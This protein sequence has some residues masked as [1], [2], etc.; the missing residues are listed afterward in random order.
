[1]TPPNPPSP[2]QT[3]LPLD[4]EARLFTIGYEGR[5]LEQYLEA[6]REAGVTLLCDVRRDPVSRKPGFS[7]RRLEEAC[8]VAGI[9]YA[10]LRELGIAKE[11]RQHVRTASDHEA[12]FAWYAQEA[13]PARVEAITRIRGWV[14]DGERVALTCYE[15]DPV[16]CHRR[17]VADAVVAA[18]SGDSRGGGVA[19]QHL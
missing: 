8:T 18:A 15:R 16:R 6:L 2:S 4:P 9:R 7:K 14:E 10:H 19:V 12:L 5:S 1:M 3:R 11:R 17:L 13:L